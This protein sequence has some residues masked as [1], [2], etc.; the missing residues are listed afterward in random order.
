MLGPECSLN[1]PLGQF[2][3]WVVMSFCLFVCVCHCETP[4]SKGCGDLWPK[5]ISL[6]FACNNTFNFFFNDFLGFWTFFGG[7]QNHSTVE[8]PTVSPDSPT[9][10]CLPQIWTPSPAKK[11]TMNTIILDKNCG[12]PWNFFLAS[13]APVPKKYIHLPFRK[14]LD[15]SKKWFFLPEILLRQ[16]K[17]RICL[18]YWWRDSVSPV[19]VI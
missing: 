12:I 19:C 1:G 5:E 8:Q 6:I 2:S 11:E 16:I 18:W 4:T 3:H 10:C 17:S 13:V 14:V 9:S 15:P 7:F